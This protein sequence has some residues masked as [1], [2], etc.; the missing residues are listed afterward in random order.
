MFWN[1]GEIGV[2][3][4]DVLSVYRIQ[5]LSNTSMR[6]WCGFHQN[7]RSDKYGMPQM[8]DLIAALEL[9]F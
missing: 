9:F 3:A 6:E 5:F 8:S 2:V 4:L 1:Q 7:H